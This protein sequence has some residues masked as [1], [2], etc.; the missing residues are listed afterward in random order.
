[1]IINNNVQSV[2]QVYSESTNKVK[3]TDKT[4]KPSGSQNDEVVLSN[5]AQSFGKVLQKVRNDMDNVRT[6]KIDAISEQIN[7]GTYEINS[8]AIAEK[9]LNSF[10]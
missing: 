1:M 6:D 3:S 7:N 8:R 4:N 2:L 5:A 10:Y 9:M